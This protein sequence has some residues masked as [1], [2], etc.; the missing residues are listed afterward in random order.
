MPDPKPTPMPDSGSQEV[1]LPMDLSLPESVSANLP[2]LLIRLAL[3]EEFFAPAV[4]AK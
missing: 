2:P 4:K 1:T 3:P